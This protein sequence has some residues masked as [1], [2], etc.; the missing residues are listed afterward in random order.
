MVVRG[1]REGDG[2]DVLD[3][4]ADGDPVYTLADLRSTQRKEINENISIYNPLSVLCTTCFRL[5]RLTSRGEQHP[6]TVPTIRPFLVF[7]QRARVDPGFAIRAYQT[8]FMVHVPTGSHDLFGMVDRTGTGRAGRGAAV[9]RLRAGRGRRV[10]VGA[11]FARIRSWELCRRS[12]TRYVGDSMICQ[13]EEVP[14]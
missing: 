12:W 5:H 2:A 10:G 9:H 6:M 4:P 13:G 1:G 3:G 11:A 7:L 8:G 14:S